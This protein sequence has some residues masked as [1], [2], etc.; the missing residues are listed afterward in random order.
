MTLYGTVE[1]IACESIVQLSIEQMVKNITKALQTFMHQGKI[2][3]S[4][5]D[6][7]LMSGHGSLSIQQTGVSFTIEKLHALSFSIT[8]Y[9][10]CI[11]NCLL[12]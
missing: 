6:V 5:S 11:S 7:I 10:V 2:C 3:P 1:G 12:I 9:L 4:T 8:L